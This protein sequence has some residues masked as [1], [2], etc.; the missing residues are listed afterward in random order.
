VK[1]RADVCGR[2]HAA[3]WRV[4]ASVVNKTRANAEADGGQPEQALK[5]KV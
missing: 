3:R 2:L 4:I 5:E 1:N